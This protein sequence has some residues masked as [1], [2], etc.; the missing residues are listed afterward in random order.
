MLSFQEIYVKLPIVEE[1]DNPRAEFKHVFLFIAAC[2]VACLC[3][4]FAGSHWNSVT[5]LRAVWVPIGLM[6]LGVLAYSVLEGREL[7]RTWGKPENGLLGRLDQQFADEKS[8]AHEVAQQDVF[9]L[10]CMHVRLEASLVARERFLDILKPFSILVPAMLVVATSDLFGLPIFVQNL[11]KIFGAALL[12]G[13]TI[14]A[15]SMYMDLAK[16]RRLSSTLQHAISLIEERKEKT[17][18]KVSRKRGER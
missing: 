10:K 9:E 5:L 7:R 12:S 2:M 11:C 8:V 18:R 4:L 3:L 14:G 17:F 13:L 15:I 1:D 6:L 16:L